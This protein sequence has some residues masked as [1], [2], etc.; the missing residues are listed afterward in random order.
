VALTAAPSASP[1][2]VNTPITF[3][4][5]ASGGT[6]PHQYKW[7][8]YNGTTWT[9]ARDWALAT[10]TPTPGSDTFTWTPTTAGGYYIQVWVRSSG[11]TANAPD[12]YRYL[13]YVITPPLPLSVALTA[14]PPSPQPVNTPI[15]FTATATGGTAPYQYKWWVYNGSTW[16]IGQSW[17]A[18]T[19]APATFP[20]TPSV[21]ATYQLQVWVRS[22][23]NTVDAPET[24]GTLGYG[25]V[26][27]VVGTYTGQGSATNASCTFPGDNG[28][29][30][31]TGTIRLTSQTGGSFTGTATFATG[32]ETFSL[33][34]AGT[35]DAAGQLS[36]T[37]TLVPPSTLTGTFA[38]TGTLVGNTVTIAFSGQSVEGADRCTVTGALTATRP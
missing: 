34:V 30:A 10:N 12:A 2:P 21:P 4:A 13:A 7:W 28:P 18:S 16:S 36:G 26:P 20:L 37:L 33:T 32:P 24:Y 27:S 5:T 29:F 1:Q 25:I 6:A 11:T 17:S 38:F 19:S 22:S 15:T 9:I 8:V 3:T 31:F 14:A 23:G 35:V